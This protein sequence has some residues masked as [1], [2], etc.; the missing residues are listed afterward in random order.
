MAANISLEIK[1]VIRMDGDEIGIINYNDSTKEYVYEVF[2]E[3]AEL[4]SYSYDELIAI[5]NLVKNLSQ[6]HNSFVKCT[7]HKLSEV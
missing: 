4:T 3:E 7:Y 2:A 6:N 5:A 1:N